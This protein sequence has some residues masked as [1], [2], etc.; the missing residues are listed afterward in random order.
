MLITKSISLNTQGNTDI[1]D[2]TDPVSDILEDNELTVVVQL[3]G[4]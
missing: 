1:I 2:I 4:E 3:I